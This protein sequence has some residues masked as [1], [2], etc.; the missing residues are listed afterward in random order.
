M[1]GLQIGITH[2]T[3]KGRSR[4]RLI[5][6]AVIHKMNTSYNEGLLLQMN[7]SRAQLI[8]LGFAAYRDLRAHR[9]IDD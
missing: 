2:F 7:P 3:K 8:P 1:A 6:S 4:R 9:R 5:S